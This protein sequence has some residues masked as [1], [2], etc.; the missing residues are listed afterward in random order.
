MYLNRGECM[1]FDEK[2]IILSL[3]IKALSLKKRALELYRTSVLSRARELESAV[4]AELVEYPAGR[5]R[6]RRLIL[7]FAGIFIA[8]YLMYCLHTDKNIADIFPEIPSLTQEKKITV[9]LPALDGATILKE[10][11][12]IPVYDSE[13][14]TAK[15]LF[16]LVARGS[17]Y[18]N[19]AMAVPATLMVRKVWIRNEGQGRKSCIIDVEP[20]EL[21]SGAAVIPSSES[22]FRRAL[23]KTI[24]TNMPSVRSVM[25]LEKGVPGTGLWEI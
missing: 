15:L 8:D 23:E 4:R 19:T 18:D 12:E 9:F 22:L 5:E 21:R 24:T 13:E 11:R 7:L 25:V 20:V 16:D 3:K 2:A 1:K 14:Q 10:T 17:V 6:N